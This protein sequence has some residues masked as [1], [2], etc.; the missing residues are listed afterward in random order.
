MKRALI[1]TYYWPPSG[2]G[3]VM[4]WL[5]MSKYLPEFGWQ[6]V[7]Y[8]PSN[9]D[10]SVLDESLE[11][12]IPHEAEIIRRPIW[13]P[14]DLYRKL[15]GKKKDAK[16]KAG[17]ISEASQGSWKDRL[18]VFIRGNLLI[19]DPR[20]FWVKPSVKFLFKYINENPVD[21]I[22]T[23]G[24]PH[25][26]HLIGLGLKRKVDIPWLADFRDPW[27]DS[28]FYHRLRLTGLSDT[29]HH[30]LEK[31]VLS[32][33]DFVT[34]V[35]M[36]LSCSLETIAGRKIE[37]VNNGYDPE[38]FEFESDTHGDNHFTISHFGAFNRDRNPANL[39]KA[40]GELVRENL[41]FANDLKIQLIG[42]TDETVL[43]S[44]RENGLEKQLVVIPHKSHRDGLEL[45]RQ[46]GVLLLPV[47]DSPNAM[48]ILPGKLYEYLALR[49][50]IIAIGPPSG[51]IAAIIAETR[52]G[53]V[54]H[55]DDFTGLKKTVENLYQ[56]YKEGNFIF[57]SGNY[58]KYSR[59]SLAGKIINIPFSTKKENNIP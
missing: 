8:T 1:I 42:Q 25:S 12:E 4:R 18:S 50:P 38:D 44:I 51:D 33:A 11:K 19:P 59:K 3:G 54:H 35:S 5:K 56:K 37:V 28:D 47:N 14:Y 21:L 41:Q 6:P 30:R 58:E 32:S 43:Q 26:M 46:S 15:T 13:E 48:G 34:T 23:T 29:I 53:F 2:G 9:P 20:V 16:F 7:I 52:S 39:W 31:K 45:L 55:F 24:P 57:N 10:P 36:H 40:L 17:Y 49:R 22:V 27:T